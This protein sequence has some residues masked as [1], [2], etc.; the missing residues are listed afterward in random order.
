ME[1]NKGPEDL[2]VARVIKAALNAEQSRRPQGEER[3]L[4]E[5]AN[6]LIAS[7][8]HHGTGGVSW[9]SLHNRVNRVILDTM[10][11]VDIEIQKEITH[12]TRK[13]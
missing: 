2:Y 3:L 4:N 13:G 7:C 11:D 6:S 8:L 5:I 9:S 1:I 10:N 12:R